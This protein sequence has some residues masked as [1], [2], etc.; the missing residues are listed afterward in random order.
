MLTISDRCA[1][2]EREDASG[3]AVAALLGSAGFPVAACRIVPD[4][5]S[6]IEATLREAAQAHALVV[7]TGGTGLTLR[8]VTPEATRAV[9]ERLL[10]GL[11]ERM[12]SEGLRQTPF[13][14]L[15][16]GLAGTLGRTLILNL[17]GAP[18]GA[19]SSLQAILPVLRHALD[20][21]ADPQTS[22]PISLLSA[23]STE[24]FSPRS[25][26]QQKISGPLR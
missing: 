7:T 10:D 3:P 23:D 24:T 9:C 5:Q 13:A 14:I 4:E 21:L 2:G 22:H 6:I 11:A 26:F 8:D 19:E 16:R 15:S 1:R 17:P 20:L 25:D 12:R 18:R